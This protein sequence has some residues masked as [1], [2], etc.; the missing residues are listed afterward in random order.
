[1]FIFNLVT[2]IHEE[3]IELFDYTIQVEIII[4]AICIQAAAHRTSL[5]KIIFVTHT[6]E[7]TNIQSFFTL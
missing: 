3:Y 7:T 6:T 5:V 2:N 4:I 1:M